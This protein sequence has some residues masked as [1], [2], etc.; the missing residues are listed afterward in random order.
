[1]RGGIATSTQVALPMHNK[2]M[3]SSRW[4]ASYLIIAV[5][6]LVSTPAFS[7]VSISLD[8]APPPLIV[9]TQPSCPDDGYL[10]TPGFWAYDDNAGVY[11]WVPGVWVQPP[12][13]GLLWTPAYW[14]WNGNAYVF[15]QGY[16]G[17]TVGFYGGVN[18]GHGYWGNGYGGGRWNNGHF[19]YNTAAN[20]VAGGRIHDTYA[21]R[22]VVRSSS[23][24][25]SYNGG[26]GGLSTRPTAQQQQVSQQ[27]HV[28]P[29]P[30]QQAHIQTAAQTRSHQV[31][32][33]TNKPATSAAPQPQTTQAAPQGSQ[34]FTGG[35]PQA[36]RTAP[37]KT[38]S[39]PAPGNPTA[40]KPHFTSEQP[41]PAKPNHEAA[42]N[43]Q[44][45]MEEKPHATS[46][47]PSPESHPPQGPGEAQKPHDKAP[48]APE[49]HSN[50]QPQAKSEPKHD[51]QPQGGGNAPPQGQ[52]QGQPGG[53]Q[54]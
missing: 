14:G 46:A 3:N 16:W 50:P 37:V 39:S 40:E 49:N 27:S 5:L 52:G 11:Y 4:L 23:N 13:V 41:A 34:Q 28:Q 38:E 12:E 35:E 29:T 31:K 15:N 32:V 51:A 48:P 7:Q 45:K 20:N 25:V 22:S 42:L 18:Y 44:A 1:M 47:Q 24:R 21:D 53:P 10:W 26:K 6:A 30:Q 8:I 54:R 33:N 2:P 36:Q 19:A 43:D 9:D 17:P